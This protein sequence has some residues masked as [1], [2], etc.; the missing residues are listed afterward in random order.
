MYFVTLL[1]CK[2]SLKLKY[3]IN[4]CSH[5][6]TIFTDLLIF[7][8]FV[9][10]RIWW[11]KRNLMSRTYRFEFEL[12]ICKN[13]IQ[14][15]FFKFNKLE[16]NQ[17]KKIYIFMHE[18][19]KHSPFLLKT[20]GTDVFSKVGQTVWNEVNIEAPSLIQRR[21]LDPH[22]LIFICL[23]HHHPLILSLHTFTPTSKISF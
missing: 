15:L 17:K 5:T 8:T 21:F 1:L 6:S 12:K 11:R 19:T 9:K 13:C 22:E 20:P 10:E 23:I 7:S 14:K 2:Y 4:F 18:Y 16:E 3:A